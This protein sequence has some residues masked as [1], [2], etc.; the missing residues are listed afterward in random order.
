[1]RCGSWT[2]RLFARSGR[3]RATHLA[4]STRYSARD[5]LRLATASVDETVRLWDLGTGQ[6]ILKLSDFTDSTLS[7]RFVSDGRLITLRPAGGSV[8]GTRRL[9]RSSRAGAPA[10]RRSPHG[11]S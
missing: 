2:P 4:C 8:S 6:E 11:R 1:M 3:S 9:C 5:G 10:P 7:V